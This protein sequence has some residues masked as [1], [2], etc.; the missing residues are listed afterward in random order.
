MTSGAGNIFCPDLDLAWQKKK[1]S[2]PRFLTYYQHS[3]RS[4]KNPRRGSARCGRRKICFSCNFPPPLPPLF[5]AVRALER[6]ESFEPPG[7]LDDS[8][9]RSTQSQ[10]TPTTKK[11]VCATSPQHELYIRRIL[12][13]NFVHLY[14]APIKRICAEMDLVTFGDVA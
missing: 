1:L 6:S 8:S 4:K 3:K 10:K 14:G 13:R 11:Q 2:G 7:A 9:A 12:F 5:G